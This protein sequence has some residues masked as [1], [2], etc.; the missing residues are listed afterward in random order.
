MEL[1]C[2]RAD[3]F[4]RAGRGRR[5]GDHRHRPARERAVLPERKLART[6]QPRLV[7][8][9][10]GIDRGAVKEFVRYLF[11]L[12][13]F[14]PGASAWAEW[15]NVQTKHLNVVSEVGE[16]QTRELATN[17]EQFYVVFHEMFPISD[18][19]D[20]PVTIVVFRSD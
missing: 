11:A 5:P 19:T 3:S 16:K 13:M 14:W 18:T 4:Q 17:L 9:V 7:R 15:I 1:R 12:A 10:E 20:E 2:R 8:S 6:K